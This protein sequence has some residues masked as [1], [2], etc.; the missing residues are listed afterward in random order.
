MRRKQFFYNAYGLTIASD[1]YLPGLVEGKGSPDVVIRYGTVPDA[2]ENAIINA[3]LF[4]VAPGKFLLNLDGVARY[5]IIDGREIIVEPFA[6]AADADVQ[7]FL[8]GPVL[9][10]LLQLRRQFVLH[11]AAVAINGQGLI[12]SGDSGV[13]KSTLAGMLCKKNHEFLTDEVCVISLSSKGQPEIVPGHPRLKL[14]ADAVEEL[15]EAI[16]LLPR[17]RN[18]LEKYQLPLDKMF[19]VKTVPLRWF[20]QLTRDNTKEVQVLKLTD[21]EKLATIATNT[22][23]YWFL[24]GKGGRPAQLKQC[25]HLANTV[26]IFRICYPMDGFWLDDLVNRLEEEIGL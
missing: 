25:R 24:S 23:R 11:G 12:L 7:V 17:V 14:W 9:A 20:C 2:L 19:S 22:Y 5:Y 8:L 6:T 16:A 4:Q 18:G 1:F 21:S 3:I 10:A 13:G 26:D 15:G